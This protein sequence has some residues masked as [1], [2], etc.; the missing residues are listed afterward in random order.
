[1]AYDSTTKTITKPVNTSDVCSAI[2]EDKH[3]IGYLCVNE[4]VNPQ[5]RYKPV[6]SSKL[7]ALTDRDRANANWGYH[8]P[9]K[10]RMDMVIKNMVREYK[11]QA[12]DS[13]V[14]NNWTPTTA[15]E[16]YVYIRHGWWYEKP[17]GGASSPY[18]LGDFDGYVHTVQYFLGSSVG[19]DGKIKGAVLAQLEGQI[20][21]NNPNDVGD[22]GFSDFADMV[23]LIGVLNSTDFNNN[24]YSAVKFKTAPYNSDFG[25]VYVSDD[26]VEKMFGTTNGTYYV[27]Y[28][29]VNK[30]DMLMKDG[31]YLPNQNFMSSGYD[32]YGT[33]YNPLGGH[34]QVRTLPCAIQVVTLEHQEVNPMQGFTTSSTGSISVSV[35][36][37]CRI[38]MTITVKNALND[39][40][41]SFSAYNLHASVYAQNPDT[42][43]EAWSYDHLL[44][45]VT[46]ST[47][48]LEPL[49]EE[50][51]FSGSFPGFNVPELLYAAGGDSA[52]RYAALNYYVVI[53]SGV[54]SDTDSYTVAS[55]RQEHE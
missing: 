18:R 32:T 29:L 41:R 5:T 36:A 55:L 16:P 20:D 38:S 4:N 9:P 12:L 48:T 39:T 33:I 25:V 6:R 35:G 51:G 24:N 46:I 10:L 30:S 49:E 44:T 27:F 7:S 23:F 11:G 53:T 47:G 15:D 31:E 2:G 34:F 40:A 13:D 14:I 52:A 54:M 42:G 22:T 19:V 21:I 3:R 28:L 8:I 1:M 50:V 37:R 45:G 43:D 26:E 17:Q